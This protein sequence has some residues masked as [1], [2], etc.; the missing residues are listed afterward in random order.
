[1][2]N[3]ISW[4]KFCDELRQNDYIYYFSYKDII[5]VIYS[6]KKTFKPRKW[7]LAISHSPDKKCRLEVF[8]SPQELIE[9][10]R[11]ENR[12][13]QEIWDEIEFC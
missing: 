3:K 5:Y 11:V 12:A 13:L 4:T 2:N 8:G 9:N 6:E 10:A 1:M 7:Y